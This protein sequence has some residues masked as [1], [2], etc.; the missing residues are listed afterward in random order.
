MTDPCNFGALLADAIRERRRRT[1]ES[2]ADIAR[3]AGIMP[4][5]L[6][7]ALRSPDTRAPTVRAVC[8]ALGLIVTIEPPTA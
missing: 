7:R 5:A 4:Q 2:E 3:L 6:S 8:V 1:G